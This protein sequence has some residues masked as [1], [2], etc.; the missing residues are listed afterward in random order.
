M[1]AS[2][3]R[4]NERVPWPLRLL[5]VLVAGLLLKEVLFFGFYGGWA[6]TARLRGRA[7][8]CPWSRVATYYHD[9]LAFD[10]HLNA[11]R[12]STRVVESDEK[13][14]IQLVSTAAGSFWMRQGIG[15][16]YLLAEHDWLVEDNPKL[17][18]RPGDIVFDC[19]AHVGV[20][21]AKALSLGAAKVVAIEPN[22]TNLECLRRNF[23][24]EIASGRVVLV[25]E[26]VWS[27]EGTVSLNMGSLTAHDSLVRSFGGDTIEIPSTTIDRLIE[28]LGLD[29]VDY[30]KMDIEGAEREALKGASETLR[31]HRPRLM[32]DSYHL[33]DDSTVLPKIIREANADY[34]F[35][36]GPCE[37][38]LD[39]GSYLVP[40][41]T[42][43]E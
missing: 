34:Q 36:C 31:R 41:S 23:P 6:A 21:T 3:K 15:I 42:F 37:A 43:Y 32:L 11:H 19:G 9:Q 27:S 4:F 18:V 2:V 20:F 39:D 29:K 38:F 16:S 13:L 7:T 14:G 35:T 1:N 30:I 10:K 25:P 28:R 24:K 33:K 22:P 12:E 40:H 26:A 17:G 8:I 5:L